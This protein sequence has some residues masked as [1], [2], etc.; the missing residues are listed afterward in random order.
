M[1]KVIVA[2]TQI[3]SDI[4]LVFLAGAIDM[5]EAD[6]WQERVIIA[7]EQIDDFVLLNP[8]RKVFT[9]ETETEQINWELNA[10]EMCNLIMMWFP[11]DADAPISLFETG[12][13]LRSGKLLL[14]VEN[15]FFREKNLLITAQKYHVPVHHSLDQLIEI[16]ISHNF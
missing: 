2:P 12:L 8:R 5:G 15:G 10:L 4:P 14:G 6:N 16:V 1:A 11:K 7:L 13:Y 3:P 9:E